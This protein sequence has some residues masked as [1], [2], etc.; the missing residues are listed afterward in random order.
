M[1][2]CF[3]N[4]YYIFFSVEEEVLSQSAMGPL[5]E[6]VT[7]ILCLEILKRY[8]VNRVAAGNSLTT[9]VLVGITT[10]QEGDNI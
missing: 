8:L 6:A 1:P 7:E 2:T 10:K 3:N 5:F 9:E 4:A